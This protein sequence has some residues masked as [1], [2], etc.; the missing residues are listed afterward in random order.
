M[1][2]TRNQKICLKDLLSKNS[3]D[4]RVKLSKEFQNRIFTEA[5]SRVSSIRLSKILNISR[6][7]IYHYRNY[8]VD[9]I[10]MDVLCKI[11]KLLNINNDKLQ[12]NIITFY[13]L[14]ESI[15]RIMKLGQRKR[16]QSLK[17]FKANIPRIS[18]I[19]V[20]N[21]LDVEKWFFFYKK[22]IDFGSR[23]FK[24][25]EITKNKLILNY[26]NYANSKQKQFVTVLPRKIKIDK[27]FLYFFGLWLGDKASGGR[28]GIVNKEPKINFEVARLLKKYHQ[29]PIFDL[30]IGH[31]TKVPAKTKFD[32]ITRIKHK[33]AGYA[34]GIYAV[35]G[36]FRSFFKYLESC[37]DEF[38]GML[39]NK[40]IIFAGLFDAEGNI[41]L[42]D[43]CFR[44]SCKNKTQVKIYQKYLSQMNL[45]KRYD[46][47]N[48]VSYNLKNFAG[49]IYPYI[50][51]PTKINDFNLIY[52]NKGKLNERFM[53]ILDLIYRKPGRA[54]KE[55]AKD[56]KRARVFSQ[57]MFL[58][59]TG[60]IKRTEY[61]KRAF[62]T[63]K[64]MAA[65]LVMGARTK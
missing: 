39:N 31:K 55:L 20:N 14:N 51:H 50:K 35:N 5:I 57:L 24:N 7:I 60:Y 65:R 36:I 19:L 48:L 44:W 2:F 26:T 46:G 64:G 30:Y 1:N 62:I 41:F 17:E 13:S 28:I 23:S 54:N 59:K 34:I 61:P 53:Q 12:K 11:I 4:V 8:K 25:I 22:L 15:R 21:H 42:E 52:F 27:D 6:S 45:Y 29:K 40:N 47:A 9:N 56:L 3:P 32:K 10:S 37:L 63:D 38:L 18:E 33:K 16:R 49:L 58:E 43:R